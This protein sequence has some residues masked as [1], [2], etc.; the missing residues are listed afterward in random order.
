[1]SFINATSTIQIFY[2]L[3]Y[4]F[5]VQLATATKN[6]NKIGAHHSC[7]TP[8]DDKARIMLNFVFGG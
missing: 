5:L 2:S 4:I 7:F 8:K 1:M 6:T 3:K